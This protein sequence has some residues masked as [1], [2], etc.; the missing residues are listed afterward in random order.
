MR[1]NIVG[2]V[3]SV[4]NVRAASGS[5]SEHH[6]S[7]SA[8]SVC[9]K[10]RFLLRPTGRVHGTTSDDADGANAKPSLRG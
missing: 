9:G 10:D 5:S 6:Y 2:T 3:S 4:S 8:G 7:S 1:R